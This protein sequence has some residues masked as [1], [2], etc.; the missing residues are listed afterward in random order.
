MKHTHLDL[1]DFE[2]KKAIDVCKKKIEIAFSKVK[3]DCLIET[4]Y[5]K[6]LDDNS[7][8]PLIELTGYQFESFGLEKFCEE[9]KGKKSVIGFFFFIFFYFW[10]IY[11]YF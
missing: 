11:T 1:S 3:L 5:I 2:S 10:L 8:Q 4:P 7:D 6:V 9:Y